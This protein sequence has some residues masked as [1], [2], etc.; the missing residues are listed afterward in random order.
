MKAS[1]LRIVNIEAKRLY[2][3][4]Q[5]AILNDGPFKVFHIHHNSR[6]IYYH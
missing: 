6:S 2:N 1:V 5:V 3:V 4:M